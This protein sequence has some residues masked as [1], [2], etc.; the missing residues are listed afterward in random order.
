M[1]RPCNGLSALSA[2][3]V[4]SKTVGYKKVNQSVSDS[5]NPLLSKKASQAILGIKKT[6]FK[7]LRLLLFFNPFA[8][9][10]TPS[11]SPPLPILLEPR[12]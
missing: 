2:N 5:I 7:Y 12:L 8:R 9:A 10:F 6:Y 4:P 1:Q 3:S 11:S